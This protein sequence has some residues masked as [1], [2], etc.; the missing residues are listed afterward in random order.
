MKKSILIVLSLLCCIALSFGLF[1]CENCQKNNSTK[2]TYIV[3]FNSDGGTTISSQQIEPGGKVTKPTDPKKIG[4]TFGGWFLESDT[5]DFANYTVDKD[6]T[7]TAKWKAN[8]YTLY[9]V[10]EKFAK[11]STSI[12]VTYEQP[13]TLP[14]P[15]DEEYSFLGWYDSSGNIVTNGVWKAIEDIT[16]TAKW[17]IKKYTISFVTGYETEIP[18]V[19]YSTNATYTLPIPTRDNYTFLGWYLN[20]EKFED[21]TPLTT[22]ITL[23]AWWQGSTEDFIFIEKKNEITITKF[24]GS[25]TDVVVPTKIGEKTVVYVAD[26]VFARNT[27]ITSVI[28]DGNFTNYTENMFAG[29]TALKKLTISGLYNNELYW[30]FGKNIDSIPDSLIELSFAANSPSIY[31]TMFKESNDQQST[32]TKIA[33]HIITY[34]VPEGTTT[35]KESQFSSF[36]YMQAIILPNGITDIERFA[37]TNCV[38]LTSITIPNTVKNIAPVA[39]SGCTGLTSITIP[40][41]VINIGN[42]AFSNCSNLTNVTI[43]NG[44]ETISD[45]AFASCTSLTD[46]TIPTSVTSIGEYA[47]SSCTSLSSAIIGDGVTVI[48]RNAFNFCYNLMSVTIGTNLSTIETNAFNMCYKLVEVINKSST[49]NITKGSD[50]NGN[51]AYYALTVKTG[52][53]SEIVKKDGYLFYTVDNVNYLL[54]YTG[55]E[56]AITLPTD[57]NGDNYSIC[58]YAFYKKSNLTNVTLSTSITSILDNAFDGCSNLRTITYDGT[59]EQWNEVTKSSTAF[60]NSGISTITCTDGTLYLT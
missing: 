5:F 21:S 57:Y 3:T 59:I 39:F 30:L 35:I 2:N 50:E 46:I 37:F 10:D 60:T 58:K 14:T 15:E 23:I 55:A 33:N 25:T 4:Y 44:V 43:E 38:N 28:F 52:G 56:T 49:L 6:I 17:E 40:G 7:I 20:G 53:V 51:I 42:N 24:I 41:S 26:D 11:N 45:N 31:G 54:G 1:A 16:V 34:I 9:L 12:P 32:K 22:N 18:S 19:K 36:V 48:K 8:E 29:C 47:F 27:A 13:F